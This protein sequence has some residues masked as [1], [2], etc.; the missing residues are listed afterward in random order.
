MDHMLVHEGQILFWVDHVLL[1]RGR[2]WTWVKR[3]KMAG[4]CGP[5]GSA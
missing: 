1:H 2:I 5:A 3:A 4:P